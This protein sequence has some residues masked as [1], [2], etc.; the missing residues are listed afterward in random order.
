MKVQFSAGYGVYTYDNKFFQYEGQWEDGVKH[1]KHSPPVEPPT[2]H[3]SQNIV[4]SPP[5]PP[6][7]APPGHG[8]LVMADGGYYEGTFY[9]GEINGHGFR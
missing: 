9:N 8:K 4:W 7:L 3:T 1:G 6:K 2:K 5:P